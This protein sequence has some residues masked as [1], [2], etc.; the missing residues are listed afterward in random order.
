MVKEFEKIRDVFE[1]IQTKITM[2]QARVK[3]PSIIFV[4]RSDSER[5]L[6]K[7]CSIIYSAYTLKKSLMVCET[8][9]KQN[10]IAK[11]EVNK[12]KK[13]ALRVIQAT[14]KISSV[15]QVDSVFRDS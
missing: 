7:L 12:A 3:G 11:S 9:R 6:H 2:K 5:V 10:N 8:F 1:D 14:G 15:N 4:S 13:N